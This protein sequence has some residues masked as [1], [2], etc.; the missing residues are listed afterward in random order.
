[1]MNKFMFLTTYGLKKKF[2]SKAFIISNIILFIL[3]IAIINIDG[4][5]NFFGGDFNEEV[6]IY[7]VDNTNESYDIFKNSFDSINKDLFSDIEDD[8]NN[9][10]V[11]L[12][13]LNIEELKENI[14]ENSDIIVEISLDNNNYLKAS[15]ISDGYIDSFTYQ[16]IVQSLNNTKYSLALENSNID[17]DELNNI[18]SPPSIERLILDEGKNSEE[19]NMNT[20]MSVVFPTII[21]PFFMLILLL[22]QLIGGEINEE[23]T[24]RSM[25][26]IISNVSCKVHFFSKLLANNLFVIIQAVL[27]F[28]YSC[29]GIFVRNIFGAKV[30]SSLTGGVNDIVSSI[31]ESGIASKLGYIIPITIVLMI[32][33]FVAYSLLAGVLASMTVN[34]E[35]YQQ[36]QVPII[37][38]CLIS[39]Y[40]AV[41]AGMFE[42]SVFIRFLS[43]VPLISCLLSPALLVIGQIGIIDAIISIV[44]MILFIAVLTKYGL[45]IYKIGI[46]NY[47]TDK[48]WTKIFKA[49]RKS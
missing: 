26:V 13:S 48:M 25:E 10:S 6:K 45:R 12:S 33:S 35:D 39:Y 46:L 47:S 18:T 37:I 29:I 30:G 21:L 31:S 3:L 44:V 41:M 15:I 1:M 32:L 19:E 23:K 4:I 42:G 36:V 34:V 20:I 28:L 14:K 11:V 2:K 49:V 38:I 22:I 27:I 16:A 40:L 9:N 17:K 7:V 5:I 43:Y 8:T 24:T